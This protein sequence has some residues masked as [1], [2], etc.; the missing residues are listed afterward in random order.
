MQ[1]SD[2]YDFVQLIKLHSM[3]IKGKY[4]MK[5][6]VPIALEQEWSL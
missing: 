5:L 3:E 1:G 2:P 6:I 4:N